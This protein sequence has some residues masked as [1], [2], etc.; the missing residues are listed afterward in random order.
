LT[1]KLLP[2]I[3]SE[4]HALESATS[5]A[6][7]LYPTPQFCTQFKFNTKPYLLANNNTSD[8]VNQ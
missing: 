2:Y 4:L 8:P 3:V 6:T 1:L 7:V 5:F